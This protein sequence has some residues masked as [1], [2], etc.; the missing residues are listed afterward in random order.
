MDIPALLLM[1]NF[2]LVV[3]CI[4][5]RT[6][7]RNFVWLDP[8]WALI[9]G[10]FVSYCIK[11]ALFI[12][13]PEMA[14]EYQ[15]M[16]DP[17][18][19]ASVPLLMAM[20][21]FLSFMAGDFWAGTRS[22]ATHSKSAG[23]FGG[24]LM[25]PAFGLLASVLIFVGFAGVLAFIQQVGWQ[26]T[27]SELLL[28]RARNTL[29][30]N[31]VGQGY[32]TTIIEFGP[33]GWCLYAVRL[34]I[35]RERGKRTP[36][37]WISCSLF[38]VAFLVPLMIGQRTGMV[39]VILSGLVVIDARKLRGR[40]TTIKPRTI[41]VVFTLVFLVAGPLGVA[42]K[43]KD[44]N[45]TNVMLTG[46]S[47]W[48]SYEFHLVLES[49][50]R[51]E[52]LYGRSYAEDVIYTYLPRLWFPDKPM[53]YGVVKVQDAVAPL[54]IDVSGTYPP[55]LVLEAYI[56]FGWLGLAIVPFA[57]GL[58][59][60][61]IAT[62]IKQGSAYWTVLGIYIFVAIVGFRSLG[63]TL[64]MVMFQVMFLAI[65]ERL[66]KLFHTRQIPQLSGA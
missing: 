12:F 41:A 18:A 34:A 40:Q 15:Y 30:A 35:L 24:L 39:C 8:A 53:R 14:S 46:F 5:G 2:L 45:I 38:L 49:H 25:T 33:L 44:L 10:Y 43:N 16:V 20:L 28:G 37:L 62:R 4:V 22:T 21:F 47:A 64:A 59:C 58:V 48:D 42:L 65:I 27:T 1:V 56:N 19:D 13:A 32:Y 55:G 31:F 63:G 11:P 61:V 3:I 51:P 9:V 29:V 23:G 66:L 52:F 36:R 60:N 57:M 54:L 6:S 26:G 50:E 7:G 17:S